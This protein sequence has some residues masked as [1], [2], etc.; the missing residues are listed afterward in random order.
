VNTI[1]PAEITAADLDIRTLGAAEHRSPL[2]GAHRRRPSS[3]HWVDREDRVLFD[4]ALTMASAREVPISQLPSF[5]PGGPRSQL[6]F[7][8]AQVGVG[9]VSCGGLCPGIN[10]VIRGLVLQ[11][12]EQYGVGTVVGFRNGYRGLVPPDSEDPVV[13]TP[14]S[15]RGIDRQGGSVLGTSR[16]AQ[17]PEA[18]V[19]TLVRLGLNIL[20]VIG[21]DGS[22]RGAAAIAAVARA[23]ELQIAVV[24][25]PKTIDNDI[26]FIDQSFGFQTAFGRAA[27]SIR[28]AHTE[29]SSHPNG[30]GLV[31]L[32]GRHSGFI[33]AY[34]SLA[35]HDVDVVL[36]PEVPFG[37]EGPGGLLEYIHHRVDAQGHCVIVLAEGAGQELVPS[38]GTDASGN[39][40][41]ADIGGLIRER[42]IA[43]FANY[44][45]ELNLRF[46]DPGYAIR[47][48]PSNGADGVYCTRLAH[49]AVHAALSGRTEMIAGRWHGRFVHLPMG[50][51]TA[52]RNLVDPD[53]DLWLAVL[54]STGQPPAFRS[55]I[56]LSF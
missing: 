24:G 6:Y 2:L 48:V 37:L 18:M 7:D 17:D 21:G 1:D 43:S 16:G 40:K 28:A 38:V 11:L 14:M 12:T 4:D 52:G 30:V 56:S 32:M 46:V 8:P 20:F 15:V 25:I 9:I 29:A 3:L 41:L 36:I 47:S 42:I 53:G 54:E 10:D 13:L 34:A 19:D 49:T 45:R 31:K 50:L 22:L 51:V 23:R 44:R 26:P 27:E 5:E 39:A 55:S 33:A 35:F